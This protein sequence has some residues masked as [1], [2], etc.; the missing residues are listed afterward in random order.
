MEDELPDL[1]DLLVL[2]TSAGLS[3]PAAMPRIAPWCPPSLRPGLDTATTAMARGTVAHLAVAHLVDVDTDNAWGD[4]GRPL[5]HAINDHL[6]HG[7]PLAPALHRVAA[8]ARA[9]RRRAAQTRARRLPI[10]LLFPLVTCT[11][12]AFGLLTVA[13]I[14]VSTLQ[15][16]DG[17]TLEATASDPRQPEVSPCPMPFCPSPFTSPR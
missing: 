7:T 15:S 1:I 17:K 2:A 3:V 4:A 10:L 6:V 8:D 9:R 13:P 11:L 12:P 5:V 16:L 14:V